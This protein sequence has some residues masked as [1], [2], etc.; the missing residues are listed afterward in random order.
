V[1]LGRDDAVVDSDDRGVADSAALGIV[2]CGWPVI[3]RS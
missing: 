2:C 1:K 3:W